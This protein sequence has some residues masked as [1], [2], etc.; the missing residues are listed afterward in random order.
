MDLEYP[1]IINK[2]GI[3]SSA[4]HFENGTHALVVGM[5]A[6]ALLKAGMNVRPEMEGVNYTPELTIWTDEDPAEVTV[7]IEWVGRKEPQ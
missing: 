3:P 5:I 1:L 6:G 2:D 4:E 7:R